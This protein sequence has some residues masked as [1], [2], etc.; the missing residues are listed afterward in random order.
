MGNYLKQGFTLIELMITL[1]IAGILL[2]IGVPAMHDMIV[3]QRLSASVNE[4][5][6]AANF[7]RSEAIK[8]GR[9]VKICRSVNAETNSDV[10]STS[11][12]GDHDSTDWGSGWIVLD[13]DDQ[14]L[15][16][17]GALP[18]KIYAIA[19]SASLRAITF[20]GSGA[21]IGTMAGGKL[22]FSYDGKFDRTVCITRAGRIRVIPDAVTCPT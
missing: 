17:Q 5:I 8:R 10:C 1:V 22:T 15:L 18:D 14:V 20:T 4:F 12:S 11:S 21:P 13:P 7:A 3:E 9:P 6:A 19:S 2:V 16:R